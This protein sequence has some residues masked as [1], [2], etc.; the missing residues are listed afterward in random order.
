M[1]R[2]K[3]EGDPLD[4]VLGGEPDHRA[5]EGDGRLPLAFPERHGV[6]RPGIPDEVHG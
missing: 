6:L 5:P 4:A 3:L 2:V 1:E